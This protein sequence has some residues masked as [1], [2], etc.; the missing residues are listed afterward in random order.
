MAD[1]STN[2]TKGN[3]EIKHC[4]T[5]YPPFRLATMLMKAPVQFLDEYKTAL[6]GTEYPGGGPSLTHLL[7]TRKTSWYTSA[8]EHDVSKVN[9]ELKENYNP[10]TKNQYDLVSYKVGS[11]WLPKISS[12]TPIQGQG[13]FWR[14]GYNR[15]ADALGYIITENEFSIPVIKV[16]CVKVNGEPALPGGFIDKEDSQQILQNFPDLPDYFFAAAREFCEECFTEETI[17]Q[18]PHIYRCVIESMARDG[19]TLSKDMPMVCDPR[20]TQNAG[21]CTSAVAFEIPNILVPYIS[22]TGNNDE[23]KATFWMDIVTPF[24]PGDLNQVI[25]MR[26][27]HN[28]LVALLGAVLDP[29]LKLSFSREVWEH[30]RGLHRQVF[31]ARAAED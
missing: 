19:I 15:A 26:A 24:L 14:Y 11:E 20:T 13:K 3:D 25:P 10:V 7:G 23:T 29:T 22:T 5:Q 1:K 2:T 16:L 17:A 4:R 6:C 31:M 21:V 30:I 12:L 9:W 28:H 27:N 18:N 8:P